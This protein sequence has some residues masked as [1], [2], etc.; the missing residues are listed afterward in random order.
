MLYEV[1]TATITWTNPGWTTMTYKVGGALA[2]TNCNDVTLA[3]NVVALLKGYDKSANK[4]KP[5][6][7]GCGVFRPHLPWNCPKDFWDM[8]TGEIKIPKGY[9]AGDLADIGESPESSHVITSYSIHYTKL[10]DWFRP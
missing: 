7:I 4:D 10:Y 1:I 8:V 9:M 5:F 2:T 6:F 3:N